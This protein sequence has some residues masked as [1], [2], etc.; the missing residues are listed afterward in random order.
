MNKPILALTIL[1]ALAS[2]AEHKRNEPVRHVPEGAAPVLA[3]PTDSDLS[4]LVQPLKPLLAS[5]TEQTACGRLESLGAESANAREKFSYLGAASMLKDK[6]FGHVE[7]RESVFTQ[8]ILGEKFAV[9]NFDSFYEKA[10]KEYQAGRLSSVKWFLLKMIKATGIGRESTLFSATN[11]KLAEKFPG[12]FGQSQSLEQSLHFGLAQKAAGRPLRA[13][14]PVAKILTAK[15]PLFP[16]DGSWQ[17]FA[18][19]SGVSISAAAKAFRDARGASDADMAERLCATVLLHQSFSQL[20]RIKGL[21]APEIHV[22]NGSAPSRIEKLS[23]SHK[24]FSKRMVT[25]AAFDL[26]ALKPILL[27]N[28]AIRKYDPSQPDQPILTVTSGVPGSDKAKGPG[29]LED[30]LAFIEALLFAYEA[31]SPA[32][33]LLEGRYILGDIAAEGSSAL[34]PA[35]MHS[36]ALGLLTMQL[37]NVAGL[38]IKEVSKTG[39]LKKEGEAAAGIALSAR[40][41]APGDASS[42]EVH[43]ADAVRLAKIA[44]FF[45]SALLRLEQK[46]ATALKAMNDSYSDEVLG[47]LRDLRKKLARLKFPSV[48]LISQMATA[49]DGCFPTMEWNLETGE[50]RLL[51]ECAKEDKM[52]AA[53]VFELLGRDSQSTLLLKKAELLRK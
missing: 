34:L 23:S 21:R 49:K 27:E 31:T 48:L 39:A 53:E 42:T 44:L 24:E 18:A 28:E 38:H 52:A 40:P 17:S 4:E 41:L 33:E 32:T 14:G 35:E 22:G 1:S 12:I 45:E 25:G 26:K 7:L 8:L 29:S 19:A 15:L 36:L 16:G 6:P 50:R 46:D 11:D 2:C 3:A 30:S 9:D 13:D 51:G 5:D 43:L 47:T 37:K 10:E 20:L